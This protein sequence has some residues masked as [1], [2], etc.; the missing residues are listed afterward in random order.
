[1][2]RGIFQVENRVSSLD[3]IFS[4]WQ[5]FLSTTLKQRWSLEMLAGQIIETRN[6]QKIKYLVNAWDNFL[7]ISTLVW[8]VTKR[9]ATEEPKK[10]QMNWKVLFSFY[11]FKKPEKFRKI[12]LEFLFTAPERL[13]ETTEVYLEPSQK[14]P[15]ELFAIDLFSQNLQWNPS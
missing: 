4:Q 1:M 12:F 8:Y 11:I 13:L 7:Y 15:M 3:R 14:S 5:H 2:F 10:K 9:L 6:F